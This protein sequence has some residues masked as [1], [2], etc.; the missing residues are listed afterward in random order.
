MQRISYRVQVWKGA[1]VHISV[2][3]KLSPER[4]WQHFLPPAAVRPAHP[5]LSLLTL[6][7]FSLTTASTRVSIGLFSYFPLHRPFRP[8]SPGFLSQSVQIP[9][10]S[11]LTPLTRVF[12]GLWSWPYQDAGSPLLLLLYCALAFASLRKLSCH[13]GTL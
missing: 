10:I 13:H 6:P 1:C 7:F 5:F 11:L 4:S 8:T 2:G 3:P 12:P 9:V